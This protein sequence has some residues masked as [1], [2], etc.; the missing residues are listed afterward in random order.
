MKSDTLK[1]LKASIEHWKENVEKAKEG[2]LSDKDINSDTCP[3]C[4]LFDEDCE[5]AG[6]VCPIAKGQVDIS[7]KCGCGH[8]PWHDVKTAFE[9]EL[10][11]ILPAVKRELSFLKSLLPKKKQMNEI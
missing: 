9:D 2:K 5:R 1:A 8:T 4:G 11:D 3:L 10:K 7:C 6:E